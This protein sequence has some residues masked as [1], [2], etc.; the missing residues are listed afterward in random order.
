MKVARKFCVRG[1]KLVTSNLGI[2][3]RPN[4]WL[5]LLEV[6]KATNKELKWKRKKNAEK[7]E[8]TTAAKLNLSECILAVR[9]W[10]L[11]QRVSK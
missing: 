6:R 11:P 4:N 2:Y 5:F 7:K 8:A 9:M 10:K 3:S 1:A